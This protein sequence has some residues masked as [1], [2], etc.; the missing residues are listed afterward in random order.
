MLRP[1]LS[2][3]VRSML[4]SI[5]M[6]LFSRSVMSNS[7]QLYGLYSARLLC[8]WDFPDKNTDWSG[9]PFPPPGDFS[10]QHTETES[11]VSPALAGRFITIVPWETPPIILVIAYSHHTLH[12]LKI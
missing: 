1:T 5:L 6:L 11:P 4:H 9:L 12:A 2:D 8:P 10:N 3:S 7:L